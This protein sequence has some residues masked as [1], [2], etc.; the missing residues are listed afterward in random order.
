[1]P[2]RT[3]GVLLLASSHSGKYVLWD[4]CS[5]S[6]ESEFVKRLLMTVILFHFPVVLFTLWFTKNL[7]VFFHASCHC[8]TTC[9]H[10][11]RALLHTLLCTDGLWTRRWLY[12][13][14][15]NSFLLISTTVSFCISAIS[16]FSKNKMGK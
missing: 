13:L 7:N 16:T 10:Y 4:P 11:H 15:F 5:R 2:W 1:M 9:V 6:E 8:Y 12:G 3:L 14:F